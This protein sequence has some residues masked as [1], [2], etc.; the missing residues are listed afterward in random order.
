M[1]VDTRVFGLRNVLMA[2]G[3][4]E[5]GWIRVRWGTCK[6]R[7]E[8]VRVFRFCACENMNVHV[9]KNRATS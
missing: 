4:A 9:H 1:K 6:N 2:L 5:I 7:R 3:N 8:Q